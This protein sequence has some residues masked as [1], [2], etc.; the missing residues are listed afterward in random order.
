LARAIFAVFLSF[1]RNGRE[2]GEKSFSLGKSNTL[3]DSNMKGVLVTIA[4]SL[5]LFL[6]AILG[7]LVTARQQIILPETCYPDVMKPAPPVAC[8]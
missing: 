3:G 1:L 7:F 6:L 5:T 4:L 2:S 8:E